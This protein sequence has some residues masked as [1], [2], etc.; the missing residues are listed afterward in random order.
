MSEQILDETNFSYENQVTAKKGE[1]NNGRA[2]TV[3]I[4]LAL[5]TLIEIP[6]AYY[7][8]LLTDVN[9]D[10]FMYFDNINPA[11]ENLEHLEYALILLN[12]LCIIFF[13]MWF[14]R[15]YKNVNARFKTDGSTGW[16]VGGWFIPFYCWIKP[17]QL[18]KEMWVKNS[19]G[20]TKIKQMAIKNPNFTIPGAW[21]AFWVTTS[22]LNNIATQNQLRGEMFFSGSAVNSF[23]FFLSI[24]S[25]PYGILAILFVYK[26]N[27]TEQEL[28]QL[29][30][31]DML[32]E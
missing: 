5:M 15:A 29:E 18:A 20:L 25:I 26:Y 24:L 1:A 30:S 16:A 22:L 14:S 10:D 3:M 7:Y 21:W 2:I 8:N 4:F 13:L 9:Y 23:M 11:E 6:L 12:I 32:S 17:Y 27:K 28:Y 31:N 19:N